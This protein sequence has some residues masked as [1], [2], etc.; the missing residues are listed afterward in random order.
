MTRKIQGMILALA[1]AF[2]SMAH[3]QDFPYD[4]F[5]PTTLAAATHE[6]EAEIAG[7]QPSDIVIEGPI[8][9][10]RVQAIYTG[11]HRATDPATTSFYG[12]YEKAHSIQNPL[13]DVYHQTYLFQ[14]S[15][16]DYWLP[17]Q[18]QVATYFSK[19]LKPGDTIYLYLPA[20]GGYRRTDDWNWVFLVEEFD[21]KN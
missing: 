7:D 15:G 13:G 5:E 8:F 3:S 17:V 12:Y 1:L 20:P 4:Q 10:R 14:E 2:P 16:I 18:D 19:E 6:F 9:R 11:Q 21:A